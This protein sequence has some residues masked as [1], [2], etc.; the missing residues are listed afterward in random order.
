MPERKET[1]RCR[2]GRIRA[3]A[4][5]DGDDMLPERTETICC[6]RGRRRAAIGEDHDELLPE[7]KIR[8]EGDFLGALWRAVTDQRRR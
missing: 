6:R 2:R 1:T 7:T 4:R 5:E 8:S 3:A